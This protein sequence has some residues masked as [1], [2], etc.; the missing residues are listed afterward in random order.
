MAIDLNKSEEN[1]IKS[2]FNLSKSAEPSLTGND[3]I[4]SGEQKKKFDLT[5][6]SQPASRAPGNTES[7]TVKRKSNGLII[8]LILGLVCIA[9][10]ILFFTN[11]GKSPNQQNVVIERPKQDAQV[12]SNVSP[13]SN[14]EANTKLNVANSSQTPASPQAQSVQ[15]KP[16]GS[17]DKEVKPA[18]KQ[19]AT[20]NANMPYKNNEFYKVY[21]FPFG[22]SNYSQTN[23]ELDK[24]A[25]VLKKNPT[26]HIYIT[27]YTDDIGGEAINRNLSVKRAKSICDYLI[28]KGIDA[29]RIKHEGKGISTKFANKAQNRRAEFE[30]I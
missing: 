14:T 26:L 2:R 18:T 13:S 20:V 17:P 25:E 24:L 27:A 23:P 7:A 9:A 21:Q 8:S 30:I 16:N 12:S 6:P 22:A 15:E 11:K 4:S 5:K 1:K 3:F 10:L 28:N 19:E 29:G